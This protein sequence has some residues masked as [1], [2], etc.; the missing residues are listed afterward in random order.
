[1]WLD[2]DFVVCRHSWEDNAE[3]KFEALQQLSKKFEA[4]EG[5]EPTLWLDKLCLNQ[6][7]LDEDLKCLPF[8]VMGCNQLLVLLVLAKLSRQNVAQYDLVLFS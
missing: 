8:F 5:R 6:N 3:D 1:M 2:S 4:N 7:Q